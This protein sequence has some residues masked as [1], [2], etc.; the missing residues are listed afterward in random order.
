MILTNPMLGPQNPN[1]PR[2]RWRPLGA[3]FLFGDNFFGDFQV[4]TGDNRASDSKN[5]TYTGGYDNYTIYISR[6][7]MGWKPVPGVTL[8]AGKQANPF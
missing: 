5:A 7:F 6:A 2:N 8:I 4:A 3:D 1:I